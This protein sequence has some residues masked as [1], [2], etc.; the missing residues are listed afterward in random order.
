MAFVNV[1]G[2]EIH[3][4]ERGVAKPGQK[5]LLFVHGAG[6]SAQKWDKQLSGLEGHLL[7]LDL[8]G[9]GESAGK[10]E[11]S[12]SAYREF[13]WQ[14]SQTLGLKQFVL[15]GHSM[16]GG[17]T[18]DFALHHPEVLAGIVVVDSGARLKVNP[19]TLAVLS[20]G[21]HPVGNVKY[22]FARNAS[23]QILE[24]AARDMVLVPPPVYLAD[25]QACD[26]FNILD[27]VTDIKVPALILCGQDD[28]MTLPKFSEFLQ[29]EIEGSRFILIPNAGHM[30]MLEKPE[31]VNQAI[32]EFVGTL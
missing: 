18:L 11:D 6:G 32:G 3:Y 8:P 29:K 22:M 25:F 4:E 9:H 30:L 23:P 12:V 17:I 10:A 31:I 26:R 14:F 1:L 5:T 15:V 2:R 20:E 19:E 21:K 27:R 24:Q 16:G 13:V 28:L 7:A